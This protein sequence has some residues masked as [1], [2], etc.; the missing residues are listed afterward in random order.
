MTTVVESDV[1][2]V[3][4]GGAGCRA[5]IE[6]FEAGTRV[7]IAVKGLFGRI[8]GLR[9]SGASGATDSYGFLSNPQSGRYVYGG[10]AGATTIEEEQEAFF[11]IGLQVGLGMADRHLMEILVKEA[12]AAK[13]RLKEWGVIVEDMDPF[14]RCYIAP[15]PGMA[16]VVRG[17]NKINIL[18]HV[19][20]TRLIIRDGVCSG[21]IGINEIDGDI[22]IF[23]AK[24][25]I[26]ATGGSG[27]LYTHT[28]QPLCITGD[29]YAIGYEAGAELL[30]MEFQQMLWAIVFPTT[31]TLPGLYRPKLLNVNGAEFV[32]NYLPQG[33]TL[34]EVLDKKLQHWPFT[35]RDISKYLEI[36]A[37][38][39]TKAGRASEHNGFYIRTDEVI[40][41]KKRPF[42][43]ILEWCKTHGVDLSKEYVEAN[44]SYHCHNGGMRIDENGETTI[45][46]LYAVGET[47]AGPYGVDRVGG[48]MMASSQ[49]FGTRAGKHAAAI[50]REMKTPLA[51]DDNL[52]SNEL[53]RINNLKKSKGVL[54]P[55]E[56][57]KRLQKVAWENLLIVKS[58]E[59]LC[60]LIEEIEGIRNDM[61]LRLS[62]E[63]TADLVNALELNNLLTVGEIIAMSARERKESRGNH[64]RDDFPDRDD[65]NWL[66][67]IT[68]KKVGNEMKPGTLVRDPEW[69]DTAGDVGNL[70]WG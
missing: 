22:I 49:V 18:E 5:A 47:A 39:E 29:G 38:K 41:A 11:K 21:A 27:Q 37:V 24:S 7:T 32:Q 67:S 62:V 17:T 50:A 35:S 53:E 46:G 60:Q 68:V 51:I 69:S 55:G 15:T 42:R 28:F 6:A 14:L 43:E 70:R 59:S 58:E 44:V 1:L 56:L 52:I 4:G 48:C 40:S 9:G 25:T 45:P 3:G 31:N 16:C 2:V 61:T 13:R 65:T 12:P 64:Y 66:H 23:K 10:L 30:N 57:K 36:A 63:D 19:M 54:K 8:G 33:T 26:L 34:N 20:V